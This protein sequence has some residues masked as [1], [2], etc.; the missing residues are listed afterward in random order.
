MDHASFDSLTRIMGVTPR[1]R[2]LGSLLGAGALAA[3]A[4][5]WPGTPAAEAKKNKSNSKRR[6]YKK[7]RTLCLNG[8]T[9]RSKRKRRIRRWKRQGATTGACPGGCTPNCTGR[10]GDDGC[11]GT[12]PGCAAGTVCANGVCQ[13]CTV[14]CDSDMVTCGIALFT[15]VLAGG[16]VYACPGVYQAAYNVMTDV[17]V[18]GSGNGADPATST[19]MAGQPG[20]DAVINA[21]MA[22]A[23]SSFT[24]VRV[25]GGATV[26]QGGGVRVNNAAADLTLQD[27]VVAGNSAT[28]GGGVALLAG[29]V[30]IDGC[31]ISGNLTST[32]DGAGLYNG[33]GTLNVTNTR[34]T[35]NTAADEGGGLDSE[36]G[37]TNLAAS[38]TITGN[39]ASSGGGIYR[40]SGTVNVNG[41]SVTGNNP[42]DC[43]GVTCS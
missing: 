19:I 12:C 20:P 29:T 14:T 26:Q 23:T 10:C 36:G 5:P 1:R 15:A 41:A 21:V 27:C 9:V 37:T 16:D 24:N 3:L 40:D 11:G 18:Y 43:V 39:T 22:G 2:L 30:T 31:E 42:D 35:G 7:K 28:E 8:T 13:G 6:R 17:R 4:A 32:E 33:G 34:I 25:S 38:V